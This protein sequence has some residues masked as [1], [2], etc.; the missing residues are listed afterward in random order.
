MQTDSLN[1]QPADS[2]V[3]S[4]SIMADS[5]A[6]RPS[7]TPQKIQIVNAPSTPTSKVISTKVSPIIPN[8]IP[9]VPKVVS[10]YE[11]HFSDFD[12]TLLQIS[13]KKNNTAVFP[14][15]QNATEYPVVNNIIL[16]RQKTA[17]MAPLIMLLLSILGAMLIIQVRRL[18]RSVFSNIVG[19]VFSTQVADRVLREKNLLSRRTYFI[20]NIYVVISISLFLWIVTHK[21]I[22]VFDYINLNI[23]YWKLLG[24]F[25]ILLLIRHA[26]YYI[27]AEIF[28]A[29]EM[30]RQFIHNNY[31]SLKALGLFIL[32]IAF[33]TFYSKGVFAEVLYY[34]GL[35]LI[36]SYL[37]LR[38][39]KGFQIM[40][41]NRV[42]ILYS[43]LY[44]CTLEI[45]PIILGV[46][47]LM[48]LV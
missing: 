6:I 14:V 7:S 12:S 5:V 15:F 23:N 10:P 25:V 41:Q 32:P 46:K 17:L 35:L 29:R 38:F 39:L 24:L 47:Y 45:L 40:H 43:I 13:S 26:I 34:I 28:L 42:S 27:F 9:P 22:F 2:L 19:A 30:V 21:E 37:V 20:L 44:L 33:G 3:S 31:L 1:I 16:P 48:S 8:E 36:L 18:Q 11:A 4:A